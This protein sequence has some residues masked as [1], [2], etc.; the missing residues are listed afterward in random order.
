MQL[1]LIKK[2]HT[3]PV[4]G[5]LTAILAYSV[6]LSLSGSHSMVGWNHNIVIFI[7]QFSI[8]S[9]ALN[10]AINNVV[11]YNGKIKLPV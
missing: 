1:S 5:P 6:N 11:D 8:K 4:T 2:F 9:K 10:T 3:G 7:L